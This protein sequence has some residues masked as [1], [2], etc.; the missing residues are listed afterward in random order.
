MGNGVS[1][2]ALQDHLKLLSDFAGER[3]VDQDDTFWRQLFAFPTAL[4]QLPPN[5][6]EQHI[7][8]CCTQLGKQ[9]RRDATPL[10]TTC[11]HSKIIVTAL[12]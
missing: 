1:Q 9:R 11:K 7:T 8:E 10:K 4:S 12:Q 2:L 6:V 5:Q 3:K